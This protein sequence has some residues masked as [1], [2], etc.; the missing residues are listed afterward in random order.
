[1]SSS[2]LLF[3]GFDIIAKILKCNICINDFRL[4]RMVKFC[5]KKLSQEF[6]ANSRQKRD[7]SQR[8]NCLREHPKFEVSRSILMQNFSP[9]LVF[10]TTSGNDPELVDNRAVAFIICM[11]ADDISQIRQLL[12][13][14]LSPRGS[15]F[16]LT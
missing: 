15:K 9:D 3:S 13:L 10:V 4:P 8:L 2:D 14:A 1:M 16:H 6:E 11:I 5:L 12:K 7:A